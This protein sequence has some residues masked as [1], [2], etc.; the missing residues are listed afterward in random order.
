MRVLL[1]Q[2]WIASSM[3]C[4]PFDEEILGEHAVRIIERQETTF[5]VGFQSH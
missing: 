3:L 1:W 5:A 2:D 4:L